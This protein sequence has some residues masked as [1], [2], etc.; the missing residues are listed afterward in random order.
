MPRFW[1]TIVRAR[2][3]TGIVS[4]FLCPCA[5]LSSLGSSSCATGCICTLEYGIGTDMFGYLMALSRAVDCQSASWR[6]WDTFPQLCSKRRKCSHGKALPQPFPPNVRGPTGSSVVSTA[7]A[8]LH[9]H[10]PSNASPGAPSVAA[11]ATKPCHWAQEAHTRRVNGNGA[12]RAALASRCTWNVRGIV[13]RNNPGFVQAYVQ[14]LACSLLA[15]TCLLA[16]A[17][18]HRTG[19][20]VVAL[21]IDPITSPNPG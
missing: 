1:G 21:P 12:S 8:T 20:V 11:D 3:P 17:P 15:H 7:H 19:I 5:I 2:C 16:A 4:K 13:A 6:L 14:W 10:L 18:C 9:T